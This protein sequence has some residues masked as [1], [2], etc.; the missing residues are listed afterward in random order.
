[1][2]NS[3]KVWVLRSQGRRRAKREL[4]GYQLSPFEVGQ[5]KAH[6]HHGLGASAISRIIS[7][8]PKLDGDD[9]RGSDA[10]WSDTTI[11][12]AM[13][14]LEANPSWRGEREV[15]SG[16]PRKTTKKDD[17][18]LVKYVLKER[19]ARRTVVRTI[20]KRFPRLRKLSNTL[21]EERLHEAGLKFLRRISKTK[22][23]TCYL[24]ERVNYCRWVSRKRQE[25]LNRWAYS[26][27]TTYYLDLS[28]ADYEQTQL[29]A[30][31]LF[32]WRESGN[33]KALYQ[34]VIGP[35]R[36]SKGQGAPVKVWG[37]LAMGVLHCYYLDVEE[38]MN[39][40]LYVELIENYFPDWLGNC[41]TVIQ[42]FEGC[43][44]SQEARDAFGWVQVNL[45][46]EYPRCS[47]DFNAIENAW[48]LVLQRMNDT[49]PSSVETREEFIGRHRVAIRWVN[50]TKSDKL[51]EYCTNQKTRA[52]DCLN[53]VPPGGRTAW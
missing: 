37:L 8:P 20:K 38:N 52:L 30:L 4:S 46:D 27:G 47:Q 17:K 22:V 32:V 9:S 14:K 29:R 28:E 13:Q 18:D 7:R 26:D 44:R 35:S 25:T 43:L 16:P 45:V 24:A 5:I 42:D 41:D 49:M 10:H 53:S 33:K 19:G 12:N 48:H 51:V 39:R 40:E 21:V 11:A 50:R 15:G 2:A 31:G 23:A 3:G 36:Y 1:M 6:M 34:D